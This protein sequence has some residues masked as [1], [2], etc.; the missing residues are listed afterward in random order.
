MFNHIKTF[1]ILSLIIV[2]IDSIYLKLMS[3]HFKSLV[4]IIQGG[5]EMVFRYIPAIFCY[6]FLVFALQYFVINKNGS[7]I[8]SAI[9]GWVIYGVFETTNAAIFKDWDIKS[10]LIDTTWG[11]ILYV[12]TTFIYYK[13]IN[14]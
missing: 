2:L 7:I 11:G 13:L 4:K 1:I 10:I 9:L 8:D 6:L 5:E 12:L 14:M 3:H